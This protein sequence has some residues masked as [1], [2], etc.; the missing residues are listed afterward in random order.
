MEIIRNIYLHFKGN[1]IMRIIYNNTKNYR[2]KLT[3]H[4]LIYSKSKEVFTVVRSPS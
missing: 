4:F 2:G 1:A 3:H